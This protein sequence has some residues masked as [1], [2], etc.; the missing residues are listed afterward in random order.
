MKNIYTFICC[1]IITSISF[2]QILPK[3]GS[4]LK[5]NLIQENS[6]TAQVSKLLK[7]AD[8]FF[9]NKSDSALFYY[10]LAFKKATN[11]DSK[12]QIAESL[13][14]LAQYN[15]SVKE[16]KIAINNYIASAEIFKSLGNLKKT[17]SIYNWIGYNYSMLYA[18]DK[19]IEYY[20]KSLAVYNN[21]KDEEGIAINFI[22]I[23]NLFFD[24]E[25]Y[26]FAKQYYNDAL[27][28]YE[29]R[30]DTSGIATCYSNLGN[31]FAES[32]EHKQ[33]IEYYKKAIE[34]QETLNEKDGIATNYNNMGDHSI[35]LEQY[36][37]AQSYFSKSLKI[38]KEIDDQ[39]LLSII[40]LNLSDLNNKLEKFKESIYYAN[41]S[42]K[43]AKVIGSINLEVENFKLL[44]IA[45]E[46]LNDKS[47]AY[48]NLKIY[49][50][51]KD[52][53]EIV[54]KGKKVELFNA[55]NELEKSN[56]TINELSIKNEL[57]QVKHENEKK[58]IYGL[59]V[60]M[61][62]FAFLIIMMINQQTS[63]K[64]AYNLLAFKNHQINTM[65]SEIQTQR[66]DLKQLNNTKD[67]FFS[68][69]AHD[70]K[71]P[72]N[73]INGFTELLIEN[74][75][76]YD[77][78]KRLKFLKIIK[79]STA[80]ASSLLNNLLIWAN[81]QSGKIKFEPKK[82][83]LVQLVSDVISLVEIQAI[84]KNIL[85]YNSVHH[86]LNVFADEN[87]LN[88]VLRNLMSNAIKFSNSGGSIHISS[89]FNEEFVEVSIKDNGIG[90]SKEVLNSLFSIENK[91]S[92]IGTAN[93]Q[94]SGLGLILCEDFIVKNGGK[95]WVEST[96]NVGSEFKFTIPISKQIEP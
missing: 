92:Q 51:I 15:K 48:E 68:I 62:I 6:D 26:N 91:N 58:V 2:G 18:E 70:L 41:K 20:F 9:E 89:K 44:S 27:E 17:A 16:F 88:T 86:N 94:G 65:N 83:E 95:I 73:S 4:E 35:K 25:N 75:N 3:L 69:I 28:I 63:K 37:N 66:D 93:E 77:D 84:N 72:F 7:T 78:E 8:L 36:K 55:L 56:F 40:Y 14:K 59:I 46:G 96:V 42:I 85:I 76:N 61:T 30:K 43:I 45:Y 87:M 50:K 22:D 52:S 31:V 5:N 54:D 74:I 33:S 32:G 12:S 71:N 11:I 13:F 57:S 19:A 10:N 29:K 80:N 21:I 64:K 24:E 34:F 67:R 81:S 47:K 1:F 49:S 79:G 82:I 38:A 60:A 53:L 39:Y 90:M 23:G